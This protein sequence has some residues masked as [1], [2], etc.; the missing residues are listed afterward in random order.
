MISIQELVKKTGISSR[1][2]RYYDEKDLLHP[3]YRS[4]SGVRYYDDSAIGAVSL[5]GT[6]LSLDYRLEDIREILSEETFSPEMVRQ[7]IRDQQD[8]LLLRKE[9]IENW[10]QTLEML[11]DAGVDGMK[12]WNEVENKIHQIMY[13][14]RMVEIHRKP[15][16]LNRTH[17]SWIDQGSD[18]N[19]WMKFMFEPVIFPE[20]RMIMA[21]LNAS[22]GDYWAYNEERLPEGELDFF[23]DASIRKGTENPRRKGLRISWKDMSVLPEVPAETYDL[24]FNDHLHFYREEMESGMRE[25]HRI[26]KVGGALY[27]TCEDP[28]HDKFYGE[29][30][31]YIRPSRAYRSRWH[32]EHFSSEVVIPMIRQIFGNVT[33]YPRANTVRITDENAILNDLKRISKLDTSDHAEQMR[34]D[35][36]AKEIHAMMK[37]QKVFERESYY[38]IIKAEKTT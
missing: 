5:I 33:D 21:E 22:T 35:R 18:P 11:N 4:E 2:L 3:V 30:L 16:N 12:S 31:D 13:E 25:M 32:K 26:L 8:E 34:L 24:V 37:K 15:N 29:W 23:Y 38:H 6:F 20:R 27:V 28:T 14:K 7:M 10:L 17:N 1:M 36:V 19:V 9:K